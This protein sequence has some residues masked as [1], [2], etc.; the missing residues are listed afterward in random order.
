MRN[1]VVSGVI[2]SLLV[3]I[4]DFFR[5]CLRI[6]CAR[7]RVCYYFIIERGCFILFIS[8]YVCVRVSLC[9]VLR[10]SVHACSCRATASLGLVACRCR[11]CRRLLCRCLYRHRRRAV[12]ALCFPLPPPLPPLPPPLPLP[13]CRRRRRRRRCLC[14]IFLWGRASGD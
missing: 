10:A 7:V 3:M 4:L 8:A 5:A 9:R 13:A 2:F 6:I 14:F 12:V 11:L 1:I